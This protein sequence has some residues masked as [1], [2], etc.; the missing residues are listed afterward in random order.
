MGSYYL[1]ASSR[2]IT[3]RKKVEQELRDSEQKSRMLMD[4][5]ADAVFVAD[6]RT[7]R[8]VYI[9]DRFESLLGYSREELLAGNI[10][11]CGDPGISRQ[12]TGRNF[13]VLHTPAGCRPARSG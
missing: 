2:D 7:E 12:Y 1:Y 10:Y 5:A 4:N 11:R 6:S 9:N 13:A 3:E 8:W